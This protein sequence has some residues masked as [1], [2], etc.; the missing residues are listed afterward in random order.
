[1]TPN[2]NCLAPI[3]ATPVVPS[4]VNIE[5]TSQTEEEMSVKNNTQQGQQLNLISSELATKESPQQILEPMDCNST[6]PTPNSSPKH[7]AQMEDTNGNGNKSES[8]E[9]EMCQVN[10]Q[11]SSNR[12]V[13]SDN[14]SQT[15]EMQTE[16]Y[17]LDCQDEARFNLLTYD[18]VSLLVDLFYLPF[19]HGGH[20]LQLLNEFHWLKSNGHL[21]SDYRRKRTSESEGPEVLE[22]YERAKKFDEMTSR[23]GTLLTRLTFCKNRSLLYDLYPYV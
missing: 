22:W 4:D 3:I 1:V 23:V 16:P 15:E 18:D 20:G 2:A 6:L 14:N 17:N 12:E 21:V 10:D 9:T 7:D 13:E 8:I 5:T 11:T 19:E